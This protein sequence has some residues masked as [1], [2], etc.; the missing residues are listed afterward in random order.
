MT[1][2]FSAAAAAGAIAF[3]IVGWVYMARSERRATEARDI[4]WSARPTSD[5][6]EFTHGGSTS[7]GSVFIALTVT[8]ETS[9]GT[10]E[11]VARGEWFPVHSDAYAEHIESM[12]EQHAEYE[13]RT[14]AAAR[15]ERANPY[16]PSFSMSAQIGMMQPLDLPVDVKAVIVWT[17]PSGAPDRQELSWRA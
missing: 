11:T 1:L 15:E 9:T 7:A 10:A 17:Y 6:F 5:G 16:L 13:R 14:R 4:V 8:G 3:G 12:R 2:V